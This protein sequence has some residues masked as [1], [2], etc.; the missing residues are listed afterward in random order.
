MDGIF[1]KEESHLRK[2]G[3]VSLKIW[4]GILENVEL[5]KMED[6]MMG[7]REERRLEKLRIAEEKKQRRL[8]FDM[9]LDYLEVRYPEVGRPA[10]D[11]P[12]ILIEKGRYFKSD[13]I[14]IPFK[15][16]LEMR[17]GLDGYFKYMAKKKMFGDQRIQF[18]Y[19]TKIMVN[20][21]ADYEKLMDG[22]K[23]KSLDK[24]NLDF[25]MKIDE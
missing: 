16:Q 8:E 19:D 5:E 10:M 3:T 17:Q 7:I 12:S 15:V 6:E 9:L 1:K 24:T 18:K 21:F 22:T 11:M 25:L 4:N 23:I 2:C 20:K 13:G 14:A